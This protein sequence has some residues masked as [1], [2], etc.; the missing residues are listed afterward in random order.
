MHIEKFNPEKAEKIS[1]SFRPQSFDDFVGQGHIARI[2]QSAIQSA[3]HQWHQLWHI[4]LSGPSGYG[5]TTIATITTQLYGKSFH[6]ITAY[7]ISKPA[8]LITIMTSMNEGDV[9]FIDEIHRIKPVLEEMLYIAM[10]DFAIDMMMG[11]GWAVRVPLK[12]FTLIGATTKPESLS[13][14]LKNRFIYNFHCTDYNES[15]KHAIVQRYLD[16][17]HIIYDPTLID[18][19][20]RKVDTVPRKIHN[21]IVTIRDYLIS[22]HQHLNLTQK[23][24]PDCES[25]LAISDGGLTHIHSRY[26][27]ILEAADTAVWLKTIALQLGINEASVENEI[28]PLLL[29]LWL[30]EK[31]SRGRSIR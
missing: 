1:L 26:L 22:H 25:R 29:K 12:P 5:K 27:H 23:I 15:E 8:E 2:I 19:I 24:R 31:S 11:D 30:I 13:E 3:Q 6:T 28:E 17:Y 21:L 9:L 10:E 18:A 4:L 16:H 20:A 14:P 7:A